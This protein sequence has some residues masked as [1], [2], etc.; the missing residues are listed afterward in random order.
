[1]TLKLLRLITII[2]ML[3][4]Y[5]AFS[6]E[7]FIPIKYDSLGNKISNS[8]HYIHC[9][10]RGNTIFTIYE[11][12]IYEQHPLFKVVIYGTDNKP[13]R[14]GTNLIVE[15]EK[16]LSLSDIFYMYGRYLIT[17]IPATYYSFYKNYINNPAFRMEIKRLA[18]FLDKSGAVYNKYDLSITFNDVLNERIKTVYYLNDM[19][20]YYCGDFIKK[21]NN[22]RTYYKWKFQVGK[23]KFRYWISRGDIE[24]GEFVLSEGSLNEFQKFLDKKK[25]NLKLSEHIKYES[26]EKEAGLIYV[27]DK[28]A[29]DFSSI[30]TYRELTNYFESGEKVKYYILDLKDF[31]IGKVENPWLY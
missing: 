19:Y 7:F 25:I 24:I 6:E 5:K 9:F 16:M 15:V 18:D 20:K 30:Y 22:Y 31:V 26:N 27:F 4:G 28:I 3:M 21:Y 13:Y 10:T 14:D 11:M 29:V 8:T 2:F 23:K 12:K 1:M 17:D